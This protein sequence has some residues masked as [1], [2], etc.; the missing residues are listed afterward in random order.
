M[1]YPV[2]IAALLALS[3]CASPK[4]RIADSLVGFGLD[5]S[6]ADCV[7]ADLQRNLSTGQL[8]ELG[9]VARSYR[10]R[11]PDPSQLTLSDLLRAASEIN[12]PAIA[13]T[14]ARAAGRCNLTPIG[15]APVE[16]QES[17]AF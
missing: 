16:K 14:I 10:Q 6:R 1:R 12:D 5:Q 7:G 2:V 8:L 15:F 3:A 9:R 17:M 13:L 4:E 11:D